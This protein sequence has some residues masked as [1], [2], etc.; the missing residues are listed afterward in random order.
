VHIIRVYKMCILCRYVQFTNL[1]LITKTV[2]AS[3]A[4]VLNPDHRTL[5]YFA[6][7]ANGIQNGMTST[8]SANLIRTTHLTGTR[9][10]QAASEVNS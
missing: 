9:L 4:A 3:I 10:P 6:A 5:Y 1:L 7:A 2:A 8:Y